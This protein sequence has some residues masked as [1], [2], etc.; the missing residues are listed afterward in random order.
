MKELVSIIM[1][2]YNCGSFIT[3][4]IRSVLA[5]TYKNWE[6]LIVDDCS[7]DNT[8]EIVADFKDSRIHY[9]RNEHNFGAAITRNKALRMAK[10]RYIAFLDSDDI[11][12]PEKLERQITYMQTNGVAFTYHEYVEINEESKL[13]G[14]YVSGMKHVR[15]F[16]MYACCW[17]GCLSVIY[18]AQVVGLIQIPDIKKNNDSAMWL[19]V[20]QKADCY[21]LSENLAQ[22]RRRKGSITPTSIWKKIGW[23][24]ILFH[25]GANMTPFASTFWMCINII[26]NSY[27]KLFFVKHYKS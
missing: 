17:P 9:Q 6:L 24:Y 7:T 1:P 21:L 14:I 18:D 16:D 11:W 20:I 13:L 4:S 23:H 3:E 5:Q 26:G 2:T 12:L 8:A 25:N 22:Y 15:K 19:Q 27:K 10:G